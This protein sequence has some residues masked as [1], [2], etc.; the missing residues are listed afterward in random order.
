MGVS[1]TAA[2][3]GRSRRDGGRRSRPLKSWRFIGVSCCSTDRTSTPPM[4]TSIK[5]PST[6]DLEGFYF[7]SSEKPPNTVDRGPSPNIEM[8]F[9]EHLKQRNESPRAP[10]LLH[11]EDR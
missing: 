6:L 8:R 4:V 10:M 1:E 3:I 7:S 2:G 11:R 9:I 5:R